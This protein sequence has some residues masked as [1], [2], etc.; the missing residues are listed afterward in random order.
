MNWDAI[1]AIGEV[2]G[3]L[4]VVTTLLIL[5]IQVRQ[6]NKSMIEANALQKAAAISKHAESI[7]I[8]RSQF[9]QSRDTMTLWLAMRDGKELDRVDVARFDNIWVNFINTQRSNFVSANVVKEKGLAAQAARSVA[10]ELSSSPYFLES[11]N[12][13]KP[14]HLL[15]SPEFVEAVDSEFSNASRNKYQHMHPGSRNRAIHHPKSNET[16]GVEK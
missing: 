13:T 16:Q 8:W 10:V 5:L 11:W 3:A 14:W 15:A 4:A 6:N 7:G 1:G 12:N 9:I 2:I